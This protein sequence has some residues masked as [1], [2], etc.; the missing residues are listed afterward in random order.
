MA[1]GRAR[2][3]EKTESKNICKATTQFRKL[4]SL[5]A[6]AAATAAAAAAAIAGLITT[7]ETQCRTVHTHKNSAPILSL[8]LLQQ[9]ILSGYGGLIDA[10]ESAT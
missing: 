7:M 2:E 3:Q 5:A 8:V 6:G 1:S 4:K 9:A 10:Y